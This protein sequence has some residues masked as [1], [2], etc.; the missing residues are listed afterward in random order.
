MNKNDAL[1]AAIREKTFEL[2][3]WGWE[4]R[5][6]L[7]NLKQAE[8]ALMKFYA[9]GP[10][11][12]QKAGRPSFW[13]SFDG[14]FFVQQVERIRKE[15]K[16]KAAAAIR[17]AA[18]E[19]IR[20]GEQGKAYGMDKAGIARAARLAKLT[21]NELQVRYQEARKYWSFVVDSEAYEREREVLEHN[22]EEALRALDSDRPPSIA[23]LQEE[24]NAAL[25]NAAPKKRPPS[26][27]RKEF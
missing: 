22:F 6:R 24:A 11:K 8:A 21:D 20:W 26:T 1:I 17:A 3:R 12:K 14:F 10:R 27:F 5:R 19:L 23:A 15:R 9:S 18:K 16:C 4:N 13:K 25:G 2:Q 7:A